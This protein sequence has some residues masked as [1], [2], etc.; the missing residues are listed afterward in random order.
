MASLNT[1]TADSV[2]GDVPGRFWP[3]ADGE[4]PLFYRGAV[5]VIAGASGARKSLISSRV[6][7]DA[8]VAGETVIYCNAEDAPV[9]Q[10]YRLD[11]AGAV[12]D[13]VHLA[14]PKIPADVE[15]LQTLILS[16][17]ATL[18]V[19][20]TADK[21]IDGAPQQWGK[22][23][24]KLDVM[25]AAT[26]CAALFIHHT[27]KGAK[28][29]GGWQAAVGGG[30]T[31]IAGTARFIA[32]IGPRP[33][34]GDETLLA[35]VKD[36]YAQAGNCYAF[37]LEAEDYDQSDGNTISIARVIHTESDVK[38]GDKTALVLVQADGDG[39]K[40]PTAEKSIAALEF[41]TNALANGPRCWA[42][43]HLCLT[44]PNSDKVPTDA[45]WAQRKCGHKAINKSANGVCPDCGGPMQVVVGLET[46]A[47]DPT[48]DVKK[49]TIDRA[50]DALGIITARKGNSTTGAMFYWQLP[51]HHPTL[52]NPR[53]KG[54]DPLELP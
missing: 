32:L 36:A 14:S 2:N 9:M 43:V 20:D 19:F 53:P 52:A 49:G 25:L 42:D 26:K 44:H 1:K 34:N 38:I 48:N 30:T 15:A 33:D 24:A 50:K 16:T 31:G 4:T 29:G 5:N 27:N 51:A 39:K 28:K 10:R 17:G 18:V 8:T 22:H 35:P 41:L 45:D 11:C 37:E 3:Y 7:A 54:A 23:L 6:V 13:Q 21:H 12:L 46:E 47:K 40:G